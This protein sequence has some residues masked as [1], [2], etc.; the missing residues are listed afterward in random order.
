MLVIGRRPDCDVVLRDEATSRVHAVLMLYA[1]RWYVIDRE[2]TNGTFVNERRIW[3]TAAVRPG[4]RLS[5][6]PITFRL[7]NPGVPDLVSTR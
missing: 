5:L 2:S 1:R 3:G 7:A 4:D 6:G